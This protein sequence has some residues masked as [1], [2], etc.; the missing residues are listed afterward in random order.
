MCSAVS[1]RYQKGEYWHGT[2]R[3]QVECPK[4]AK[5]G[6]IVAIEIRKPAPGKGRSECSAACLNGKRSCDCRCFGKCHGAGTCKCE[7]A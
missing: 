5:V 2:D 4:C 6:V 7:V 1:G 3:A